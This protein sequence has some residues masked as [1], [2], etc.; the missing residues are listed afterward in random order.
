MSAAWAGMLVAAAVSLKGPL[1]EAAVAFA[2]AEPGEAVTFTFGSS[3]QLVAQIE[4][5]APV[6]LFVSASPAEIDR[7]AGAGRIDAPERAAIAGNRLVAA[8][9]PS[10]APPRELAELASARFTRVAIGNP[11]TVP[12]GRYARQALVAAGVF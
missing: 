5:G 7:L 3:G 1:Q 10:V 4:H 12:A 9:G 8:A 6:D 11:A 2:A